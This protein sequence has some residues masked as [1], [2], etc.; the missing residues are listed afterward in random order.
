M[1][2]A[3]IPGGLGFSAAEQAKNYAVTVRTMAHEMAH[4]LG[5]PHSDGACDG[6]Y[7]MKAEGFLEYTWSS[8]TKSAIATKVYRCAPSSA[9]GIASCDTSNSCSS[10]QEGSQWLNVLCTLMLAWMAW[11]ITWDHMRGGTWV[12]SPLLSSWALDQLTYACG[13][14]GPIMHTSAGTDSIPLPAPLIRIGV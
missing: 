11:I 8:C 3:P 5:A 4:T 2:S 6:P 9:R 1:W 10:S 13:R 7:I 14:C 12:E